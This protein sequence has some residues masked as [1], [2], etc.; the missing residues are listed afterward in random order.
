[1][2]FASVVFAAFCLIA[3]LWYAFSARKHYTGP[4]ISSKVAA[5]GT[6]EVTER[7]QSDIDERG[8]ELEMD[9]EK[10]VPMRA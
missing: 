1:M 5:D 3:V 2:N 8:A 4:A 10:P 6:I 7:Y 9:G